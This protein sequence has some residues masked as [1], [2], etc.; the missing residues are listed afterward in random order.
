MR[1]QRF[2]YEGWRP[3]LIASGLAAVLGILGVVLFAASTRADFSGIPEQV[4]LRDRITTTTSGAITFAPTPSK[5]VLTITDDGAIKR[6][7]TRIE[8]LDR[9]ELLAVVRELVDLIRKPGR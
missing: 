7:E 9:D 6:G 2:W 4:P 8:D 1:D 5:I 3:V